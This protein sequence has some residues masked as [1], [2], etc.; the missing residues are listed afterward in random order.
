M[1][2]NLSA[3]LVIALL[4]VGSVLLWGCGGGKPE[5]EIRE[6]R[7]NLSKDGAGKTEEKKTVKVG[8]QKPKTGSDPYPKD[9]GVSIVVG[10]VK[11][12][13]PVPKRPPIDVKADPKCHE[14][15]KG[16]ELLSE[17]VVCSDAGEVANCIVYVSEGLEKYK[18][19]APETPVEVDQV[20]CVY[21]PHTFA[22]MVGQPLLIK[23][24]DPT[25]HNVHEIKDL[26]NKQQAGKGDQDTFRIE[27][28][29]TSG[30]KCDIHPWM[31]ANYMTFEHPF[32]GVSDEKGAF[33]FTEKL[34]PGKYKLVCWHQKL[35]TVEK[36]IEVKEGEAEVK[37]EF[38]FKKE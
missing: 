2:K 10:T 5:D 20:G 26:F 32:F 3:V 9:K 4:G 24:G 31:N 21:I 16:K 29:H 22:L 6:A 34:L 33:K 37:V 38:E 18:F 25:A 28:A 17:A 12:S 30:L 11:L 13:G 1:T 36:E 23:N 15:H 14:M 19:E 35:K 8:P 27:D 7:A